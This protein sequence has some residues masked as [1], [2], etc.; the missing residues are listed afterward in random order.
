[1][2]SIIYGAIYLVIGSFFVGFYMIIL[3]GKDDNLSTVF[4]LFWP[5]CFILSIGPVF[6]FLIRKMQ[7]TREIDRQIKR[8][9]E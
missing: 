5:L 3:E 7:K 9:Q 1:M 8:H 6:W 2:E 4:L